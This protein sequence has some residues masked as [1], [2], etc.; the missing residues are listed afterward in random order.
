[1]TSI[2][3]LITS[4]IY[5]KGF[6]KILYKFRNFFKSGDSNYKIPGKIRMNLNLDKDNIN[7]YKDKPGDILCI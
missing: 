2:I 7:E 3:Q 6:A 5:V 1:M 4:S